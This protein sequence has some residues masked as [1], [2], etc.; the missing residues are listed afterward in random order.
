MQHVAD[1]RFH[2]GTLHQDL[3]RSPQTL[4]AGLDPLAQSLLFHGSLGRVLAL[5]QHE[6]NLTMALQHGSPLGF[7]R[8]RREHGLNVDRPHGAAH[9]GIGKGRLAQQP[10]LRGPGA[11]LAGRP[12]GGLPQPAHLVH[13]VL[14]HHVEE[15]KGHGERLR[16][17]LRKPR[18]CL[19]RNGE[20]LLDESGEFVLPYPGQRCLEAPQQ[21]AKVLVPFLEFHL[22]QAMCP[23]RLRCAPSPHSFSVP[24]NGAGVSL[25]LA[26]VRKAEKTGYTKTRRRTRMTPTPHAAASCPTHRSSLASTC[27]AFG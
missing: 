23:R 12:A 9:V 8:V 4:Q 24:R 5:H 16:P 26:H 17:S 18:A 21:E 19:G 7:R 25:E 3:A 2:P 14:F 13:G 20:G 1:F 10:Q 11:R 27:G 22:E 15:L 6:V